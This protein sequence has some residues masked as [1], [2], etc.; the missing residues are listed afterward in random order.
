MRKRGLII[1]LASLPAWAVAAYV[2]IPYSKIVRQNPG[3]DGEGPLLGGGA[4]VAL[5]ASLLGLIFL[6]IDFVSWLRLRYG[7]KNPTS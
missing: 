7:R 3:L 6:L 4:V 2:S 1:L 5:L